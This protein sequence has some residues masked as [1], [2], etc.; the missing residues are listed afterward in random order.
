MKKLILFIIPLLLNLLS[1]KSSEVSPAQ[2]EGSKW[3]LTK[4]TPE[5]YVLPYCQNDNNAIWEFKN[6]KILQSPH[7]SCFDY[8]IGDYTLEGS[9]LIVDTAYKTNDR[10]DISI[11]GNT[12]I[13]VQHVSITGYKYDLNLYFTKQ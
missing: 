1:C 2:L 13:L 9:T 7:S 4:I 5:S 12:M 3:K 6:G 10:I 11:T 8:F